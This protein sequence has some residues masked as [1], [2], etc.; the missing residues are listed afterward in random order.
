[1]MF[2]TYCDA[3]HKRINSTKYVHCNVERLKRAHLKKYSTKHRFFFV[4]LILR[5]MRRSNSKPTKIID[6][7]MHLLQECFRGV[8][9]NAARS[10]RDYTLLF[11]SSRGVSLPKTIVSE[12]ARVKYMRSYGN[13]SARATQFCTAFP[14]LLRSARQHR[15]S[16]PLAQPN[17]QNSESKNRSVARFMTPD[18]E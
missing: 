4:S 5:V 12:G 2:I 1:M 18:S 6:N 17:W 10:S 16:H 9:N 11:I 15:R 7:S 13:S 8:S 3:Y 14:H